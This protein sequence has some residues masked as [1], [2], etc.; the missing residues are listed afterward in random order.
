MPVFDET[1]WTSDGRNLTKPSLRCLI[2]DASLY[3]TL[4]FQV[5]EDIS[6]NN[7]GI[8]MT[9]DARSEAKFNDFLDLALLER[10]ALVIT[11]EYSCPWSVISQRIK[12]SRLCAP[13]DMWI[14]GA[15][16]ISARAFSEFMAEHQEVTWICEQHLVTEHLGD[17]Q[18]FDPVCLILKTTDLAGRPCIVII[19]QFKNL[20]FGGGDFIWERDNLIRGEKFYVLSNRI[21]SVKLVTQ[22]CSDALLG[23]NFNEVQDG[24]FLNSPL[25]LVHIQLNQRPFQT[26]YKSYRNLL[27]AAGSSESSKEVICLNWAGGVNITD[28][29][30]WNVYGGSALYMKSER[31]DLSDDRLDQNHIL[32]LYYN[33]WPDRRSQVYF[34]GYEEH[35]FQ[36][37]N[38]KVSQAAADPAQMRRTGPELMALYNWHNGWQRTEQAD[39]GFVTLCDALEQDAGDLSCIKAYPSPITVERLLELC[40]GNLNPAE[41][42]YQPAKLSAYRIADDEFNNRTNFTHD[43]SAPQ[44]A[45]REQRLLQYGFL[46]NTIL[47]NPN[48]LPLGL[49]DATIRFDTAPNSKFSFLLNLQSTKTPERKGTGIYLGLIPAYKAKAV[50]D[51]V[52]SFFKDG[53]QGKQVIVWYMIQGGNVAIVPYAAQP[54]ITENP[55]NRSNSYKKTKN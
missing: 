13:G 19:V 40:L 47:T 52:V 9:D 30:D 39:D 14:I 36:L 28:H 25:L 4:L 33:Y 51:R 23:I 26:N 32:G 48:N 42:W 5:R 1:F 41:D 17:S 49:K 24:Y 43:P 15:Q 38:T 7:N 8:W 44:R 3:T 54:N 6:Y 11:P 27:F 21:A 22:I 10:A 46:K 12:N 20:F 2:Q 50:H 55:G 31:L 29:P 37:R 53:Q 45:Q 34:L 18:F 16:A 35:V